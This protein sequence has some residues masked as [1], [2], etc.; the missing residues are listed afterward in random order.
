MNKNELPGLL[1]STKDILNSVL[2]SKE[3]DLPLRN[4]MLTHIHEMERIVGRSYR[5]PI[6]IVD[7]ERDHL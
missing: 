4:R 5:K 7:K 2:K 1:S 6:F 3:I